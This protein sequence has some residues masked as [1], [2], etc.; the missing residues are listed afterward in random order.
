MTY[1]PFEEI[2]NGIRRMIL[3]II[4]K[5]MF[6]TQE[7]QGEATEQ[8]NSKKVLIPGVFYGLNIFRGY[9]AIGQHF[10][11]RSNIVRLDYLLGWLK[12]TLIGIF[13]GVIFVLLSQHL[14]R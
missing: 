7:L 1:L 8:C 13:I 11:D 3:W 4:I 2:V 14:V 12:L 9:Q 6:F 5:V 10:P